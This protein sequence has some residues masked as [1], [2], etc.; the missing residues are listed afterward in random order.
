MQY[1]GPAS[2]QVLN[3]WRID[4]EEYLTAQEGYLCVCVDPRGTNGRGRAFRSM[5]YMNIGVMEAEDQIAAANYLVRQGLAD[6]SHIALWGWSYG[7]YATIRTLLHESSPFACGIAV[8]PVTDWRLYDSAYTERYMRRPQ[9]N[10][11]GY[12]NASLMGMA[13]NL[14]ARLFVVH[15]MA[16]DNV[17]V[18]NTLLLTEALT[19]AGKQ[20]EMQLY[21]D[22]NHFLRQRS[23]YGH[24]YHRM[25]DFLHAAMK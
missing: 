3:R 25:L 17:H 12:D 23:N 20:Y 19:A 24:L 9:V 15:G 6:K 2:Q 8:A 22:D 13:D 1:S 4:W 21:P 14:K 11:T 5:T 16:D 7:G 18:Q 10:E